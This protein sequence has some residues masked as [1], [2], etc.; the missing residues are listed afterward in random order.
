VRRAAAAAELEW[1][2][3]DP[4]IVQLSGDGEGEALATGRTGFTARAGALEARGEV[5]IGAA[6]FTGLQLD[7]ARTRLELGQ[8]AQLRAVA[9]LDGGF[10]L[11]VT[12]GTLGTTY[13]VDDPSRISVS[14]D[15]VI[16]ALAPGPPQ[17][18]V[19]RHAGLEAE[20]W[21]ELGGGG[22]GVERLAWRPDAISLAPGERRAELRVFAILSD[23][24]TQDLTATVEVASEDPSIAAWDG[25]ALLA[26][27]PGRTALVARLGGLSARCEVAVEGAGFALRLRFPERLA[28]G[29]VAP[30]SVSAVSPAGDEVD[31]TFDPSLRVIIDPPLLEVVPG[32]LRA[33]APGEA[34]VIVEYRGVQ[35]V[36]A[37]LVDAAPEDPVVRLAFEPE[38]VLLPFDGTAAVTLAGYTRRGVRRDLSADPSVRYTVVSGM[39]GLTR[40]PVLAVSALVPGSAAVR[41]ELALADGRSLSALLRVEVAEAPAVQLRI[42]PDPIRPERGRPVTVRVRALL[43]DGSERSARAPLR[44]RVLDPSIASVD[45]AGT[46]IGLG[47]GGTALEVQAE[48]LVGIARIE[49]RR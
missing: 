48:G 30:W 19:A 24:S 16:E 39:V 32:Q 35:A 14:E 9:L 1:I 37:V 45:A 40:G 10:T 34:R 26:L 47:R 20:S 41:A 4:R 6:R 13:A 11:D 44:F 43:A 25:G 27:R 49:V 38:T 2:P 12:A 28:V 29:D 3:H 42:D 15:G 36:A 7:P 33:L 17:R 21:V 5:V 8:R 23:G 18:V 31:L 22:V 46:V